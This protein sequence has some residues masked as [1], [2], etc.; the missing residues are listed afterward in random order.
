MAEEISVLINDTTETVSANISTETNGTVTSV[1]VTGSVGID[2]AGSPIT[3]SGTIA[4]TLSDM[5]ANTIKGRVLASGAPGDLSASQVRMMLNVEDGA[6]ADQSDAEIETAYNNQVAVVSQVA[7]EA[8]T[9]TT[10]ERWT[11]QRV[12]QAIAALAASG[13]IPTEQLA[14]TAVIKADKK[15]FSTG[16]NRHTQTADINFTVDSTGAVIDGGHI[17]EI[18]GNGSDAIF[19]LDFGSYSG[20]LQKLYDRVTLLN[21][22]IYRFVFFWNGVDMDISIGEIEDVL[23]AQLNAPSLS[24]TAWDSTTQASM[25]V[26]DNNTSPNE[27]ETEVEW[28]LRDVNIWTLGDTVVQDGTSATITGLSDSNDYDF[29]AKAIGDGTT[30]SDSNYSIIATLDA[31]SSTIYDDISA[32][33]TLRRPSMTTLW[34]NAVLKIRRSS[35]N[36]TAYV[37]FDGAGAN[38][39]LSTSS[40]ISTTSETTPDATTLATWLGA[41]DA[42]VETQYAITTNNTISASI[43]PV[44]ATTGDQPRFATAGV[45]DTENGLPA[46]SYVST[47]TLA[48]SGAIT[49]MNA[50]SSFT[51]ITVAQNDTTAN[52]GTVFCSITTSSAPNERFTIFLDRS[53]GVNI[54]TIKNSGSTVVANVYAAQINTSAQRLLSTMVTATTIDAY[55][56]GTDTDSDTWSGTYRNE[57][58]RFGSLFSAGAPLTGTIQEVIIWPSDKTASLAAI[59][60]NIN[61]YY[62]I[63]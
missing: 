48:S 62:S 45:I 2:A 7:A 15:Y 56:N 29:R 60:A 18:V 59:H 46:I 8:G 47:D 33:Y 32:M 43:N 44:Q 28:S 52:L 30:S 55:Y 50:G 19:S 42:F 5:A 34:T 9:S 20:S 31:S 24:S 63:Y 16:T 21:T 25:T 40:F 22:I 41:S 10:P 13:G 38:A 61:A 58:V 14:Y 17:I 35:D 54:N 27:V 23:P 26:T 3:G 36:A 6:T 12:A 11:P 39:P 57:V 4:L 49:A 53:T 37:F 1:A 51:I